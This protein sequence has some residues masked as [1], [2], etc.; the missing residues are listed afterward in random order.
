MGEGK[1]DAAMA[2][3]EW[4]SQADFETGS[5][6]GDVSTSE[7]PGDLVLT[8]PSGTWTSAAEQASSWV[9]WGVLRIPL[10]L[11]EGASVMARIKTATSE[12]GLSG[13]SWS[14]YLGGLVDAGEIR[15]HAGAEFANNGASEGSWYQV[16]LT[17]KKG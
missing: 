5:T 17:L 6:T 2:K 11:P 3:L 16:E 13:A 4:T 7:S 14:D 12:G 15:I 9:H 1:G 8:G 10:Y